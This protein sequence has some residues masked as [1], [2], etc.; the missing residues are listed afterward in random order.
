MVNYS[1]YYPHSNIV[2]GYQKAQR[3]MI[4]PVKQMQAAF[5]RDCCFADEIYIDGYSLG[6]EHI[7]ESIKTAVR[8]STKV[9]IKIVDSFFLK[10]ELDFQMAIKLFPYRQEG[11][12]QPK[13]IEVNL[14]TFCDG[15]FILYTLGFREILELQTVPYNA[16]GE[17]LA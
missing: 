1:P 3:T 14:H 10:N 11:I 7:N 17:L 5:D 4:I 2:T 8:H 9:R 16:N 12:M 6:D 13:T 15:A